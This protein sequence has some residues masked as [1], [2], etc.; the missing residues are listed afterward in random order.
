MFPPGLVVLNISFLV[1]GKVL[2]GWEASL[3]NVV[4]WGP[5]S[6][7]VGDHQELEI[8]GWQIRKHNI[9]IKY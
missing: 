9:E 1:N 3:A 8:P 6:T 5:T 2:L 4:C 7:G